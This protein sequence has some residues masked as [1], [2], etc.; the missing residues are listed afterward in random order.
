LPFGRFL[1]LG[2]ELALRHRNPLK[3]WAY[4]L[5]GDLNL[6][7]RARSA[8]VALALRSKL[9][10]KAAILDAGCGEGACS[11]ALTSLL[12]DVRVVG[13]DI[14]P[15][16]IAACRAVAAEL[17]G[18]DLHFEQADVESLAYDERFDAAVCSEVLEHIQEDE[19]ALRGLFR[20]LKPSGQLVV[21]VPLRHQL[22]QRVL[23]GFR[24]SCVFD[25]VRDEYLRAE[26]V[27]KIERAGFRVD[28]VDATF[29]PAGELAFELNTLP[30]GVRL[31]RLMALATLPIAVVLAYLD[32]VGRARQQGNSLLV[33]AQKPAVS[34]PA[35]VAAGA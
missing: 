27:E 5:V 14:D 28:R 17:P 35:P 9:P 30:L 16:G 24:G 12:G 2:Q 20:A 31:G 11:F 18:R 32:V 23:P 21:H 8:H 15:E 7:R 6:H 13:V 22:Q 33:L 3:R 1:G 29:G 34:E 4:R 25:H 19:A 26:I 10:A